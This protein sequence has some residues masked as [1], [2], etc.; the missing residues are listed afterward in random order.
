MLFGLENSAMANNCF[1]N[2]VVQNI[3]HLSGFKH[4]LKDSIMATKSLNPGKDDKVMC[5]LSNL[6]RDI[7]ES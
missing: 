5:E 1:I 4:V 7:K 6:L 3:W 2:V